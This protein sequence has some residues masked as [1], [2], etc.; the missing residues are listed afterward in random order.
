VCA[1]RKSVLYVR[2]LYGRV[3]Y[4]VSLHALLF[5][6]PSFLIFCI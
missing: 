2:V 6:F 1:E 3:V 5:N 4:V